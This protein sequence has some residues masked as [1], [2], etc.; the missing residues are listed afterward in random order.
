MTLIIWQKALITPFTSLMRMLIKFC[1]KCKMKRPIQDFAV[2]KQTKTG[3]RHRCTPCRNA[4]R[5]ELYRNPELK[6]WNKF[7]TFDKCSKEALRYS[8]RTDFA[9]KSC[10]AYGR[11]SIEGFLDQICGHMTSKRVPYRFWNFDHCRKEA[12]KYNTK[13]EFKRD[14][15]S[16]YSI[17]LRNGWIPLICRHMNAIGNRYKRLVYAYE[18]SNNVVYVGLTCSKERR[19][20]EHINTKISPVY[21]YCKKSKL[22]PVFKSLSKAYIMADKAQALEEKAIK[23]YK[24]NGWRILNRHKAGG[25]GWSEK[26][27]T[28]DNCQKEAL[29]YK[30][31]SDF[32]N[33][34]PSA[35]YLAH[36]NKWVQVFDHMVYKKLPKGSWTYETCRQAALQCKTRSEFR[37]KACGAVK[38]AYE[39]GF[40]EEIVSHLAKWENKKKEKK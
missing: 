24:K 20:L 33:N 36:R 14:N 34:N 12:L 16:A 7:W 32:L 5:R 28:F 11:A 17:S 15:S 29:K 40:Y 10:S 8:N 21:K 1:T 23:N 27:W 19:H 30:T 6:N 18:F 26:K 9:K 31:R 39:E 3:F 37:L 13:A 38:K 25:L 22:K 4:R 2:C 35:Y